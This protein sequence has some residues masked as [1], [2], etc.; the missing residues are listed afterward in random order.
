M[1]LRFITQQKSIIQFTYSW[2]AN[3][4]TLSFTPFGSLPWCWG[5]TTSI[6]SS[7][8]TDCR[9]RLKHSKYALKTTRKVFIV[10]NDTNLFQGRKMRQLRCLCDIRQTIRTVWGRLTSRSVWSHTFTPGSTVTADRGLSHEIDREKCKYWILYLFTPITSAPCLWILLIRSWFPSFDSRHLIA[11]TLKGSYWDKE[12]I[13]IIFAWRKWIF[14]FCT[15]KPTCTFFIFVQKV[16]RYCSIWK[17]FACLA[18]AGWS[19]NRTV[20]F[21]PP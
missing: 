18:L 1:F 2:L 16:V 8:N 7:E 12:E 13:N 19:S 17:E 15:E 6:P 4:F 11:N 9:R 3:F 5:Q 20:T 14:C 10:F 21:Y